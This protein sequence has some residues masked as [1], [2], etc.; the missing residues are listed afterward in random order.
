MNIEYAIIVKNKT[1]LESLIERFNTKAQAKFYIERSGGNYHDY[2]EEHETFH[3]A[4]Q[5]LQTK[6]SKII[7]HKTVERHF[8]PSYIFSEK[9]VV[10]VIG[11]DGLVANTAKYANGIP[12]IAV[13]PDEKRYDGVLLP[14]NIN[15]F[16]AAVQ[17]VINKDFK[18]KTVAFAEVKLQDGQTLLAFNDLFIGS[19]T[20]V[21][22]RYS[23]TF[24]KQTEEHSSSGIIISTKAGSTGWLSSVFNMAY[25]IAGIFDKKQKIKQPDLKEN[26]LLFAVREPFKSKRSQISINA[27]FLNN[28][29]KL[30]IESQMPANGVI[31]SDGIETDFLQ[32]NSGAIATVGLS[33]KTATLVIPL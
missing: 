15:N 4:L 20:H 11:Q 12:I 27:G 22:S 17:S 13:N 24:K 10:I 9:N 28:S 18:Y 14:Y 16:E 19:A 30:V 5:N 6:L 1:R 32:F 33:S 8:I 23:I 2:F 25:G 21:S 29:N 31:F 3:L 26:E 7:K